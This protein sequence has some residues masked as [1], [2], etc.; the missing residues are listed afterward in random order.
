ME[1]ELEVAGK[2]L[3]KALKGGAAEAL[4]SFESIR[5]TLGSGKAEPPKA[6]AGLIDHTLLKPD[7]TAEQVKKLCAEAREHHFASVCINSG[8]VPLAHAQLADTKVKVCTVVGFPLG[9]MSI[10]G[11]ARETEIAIS[12]G[13]QEI[14]M[15]LAVGRLKGH[16][17][18]HVYD[19][20]HAVV[21]AASGRRVK[22]IIETALLNKKEKIQA[23]LLAAA[24][25]AHFVKTSTGFS[26]GGA[27]VEDVELMKEVVRD[28]L[29]VKASGGVRDA[30]AAWEMVHAGATRL[31]TSSGIAIVQGEKGGEGY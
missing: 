23:C 30:K 16:E 8:F 17:F 24:A 11:K 12:E 27:T 15:V 18:A 20:I 2:E 31:G 7:A 13:A 25:R 28:A 4:A 19:D 3:L 14:D 10:R 26:G 9:A 21:S 29:E 6:L 5:K 22:V 1:F